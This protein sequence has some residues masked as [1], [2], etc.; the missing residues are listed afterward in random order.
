MSVVWNPSF[1]VHNPVLDH[2]HQ[3]I[4]ALA[5]RLEAMCTDQDPQR[6]RLGFAIMDLTEFCRQHLRE[7]EDYIR[8]IGYPRVDEH[9]ASHREFEAQ[10]HHIQEKFRQA[11]PAQYHAIVKQM[12]RLVCEWLSGHIQSVDQDYVA[13]QASS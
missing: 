8:S 12:T 2:Q 9:I 1:S 7:E 5:Q 4:F 11:D 3:S 10:V 13:F 6:V